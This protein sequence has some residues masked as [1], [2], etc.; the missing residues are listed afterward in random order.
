MIN[1]L[2]NL[3]LNFNV[4]E[5]SPTNTQVIGTKTEAIPWL[6]TLVFSELKNT[7]TPQLH[8]SS[9]RHPQSPC[10]PPTLTLALAH[11]HWLLLVLLV[12]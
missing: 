12:S 7:F 10:T 4:C 9:H 3:G 2:S 11:T 8:P 5:K 1:V 6:I